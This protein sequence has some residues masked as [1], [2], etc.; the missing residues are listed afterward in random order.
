MAR[1]MEDVT[2]L[3]MFWKRLFEK[4]SDADLNCVWLSQLR[5][6][7]AGELDVRNDDLTICL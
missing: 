2:S 4:N 3:L 7:L 6:K 1:F 5:E